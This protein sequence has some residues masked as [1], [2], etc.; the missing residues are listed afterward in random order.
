MRNTRLFDHHRS[1]THGRMSVKEG[2]N[3]GAR[4]IGEYPRKRQLLAIGAGNKGSQYPL[5]IEVG[6]RLGSLIHKTDS[7]Q[8]ATSPP[9][10]FVA[11]AYA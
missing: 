10:P 2:R 6:G 8:L 5:Q 11:V 1:A 4:S 7:I 3:G 9:S